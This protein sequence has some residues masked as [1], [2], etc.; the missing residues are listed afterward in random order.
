MPIITGARIAFER[1]CFGKAEEVY[2]EILG[3]VVPAEMFD[4]VSRLLQQFRKAAAPK[5]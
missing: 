2:P 4:E 1:F 3:A 5:R